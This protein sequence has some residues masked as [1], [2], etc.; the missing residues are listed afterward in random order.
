MR[1]LFVLL[2]LLSQAPGDFSVRGLQHLSL[3]DPGPHP[4]ET[5][6]ALLP[7]VPGPPADE[8]HQFQRDLPVRLR[9]VL[10]PLRQVRGAA[11]WP[12]SRLSV[13]VWEEVCRRHGQDPGQEDAGLTCRPYSFFTKSLLLQE[14][15]DQ[16]SR[17]EEQFIISE[18]FSRP[19][20]DRQ[21][22]RVQILEAATS[23]LSWDRES[24]KQRWMKKLSA[25]D[26]GSD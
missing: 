8:V 10:Y 20:H 18:H 17:K 4:Q 22:L 2:L 21:D 24:A 11:K 1:L 25:E 14:L 3:R 15:L 13:Q 7:G 12:H 6:E 23:K 16:I 19:D 26:I 9:G 5:E